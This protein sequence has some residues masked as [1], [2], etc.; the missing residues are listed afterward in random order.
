LDRAS[1]FSK[2]SG[3]DMEVRAERRGEIERA[4]VYARRVKIGLTEIG[5]N[6]RNQ[7]I[8]M[9]ISSSG[10]IGVKRCLNHASY[11]HLKP[12][13]LNP[14]HL[15][16]TLFSQARER[17]S[18]IVQNSAVPHLIPSDSARTT[19]TRLGEGWEGSSSAVL[20][21]TGQGADH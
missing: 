16:I 14:E 11:V 7:A 9:R 5:S 12:F 17:L 15:L 2:F 1:L 4:A 6:A 8:L 19:S 20:Q 3:F 10:R 13:L 21:S 18:C